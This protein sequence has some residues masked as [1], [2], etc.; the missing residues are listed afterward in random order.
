MSREQEVEI[1]QEGLSMLIKKGFAFLGI[2]TIYLYLLD[3]WLMITWIPN[4]IVIFLI[5][6]GSIVLFVKSRQFL[7][8]G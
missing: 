1:D 5:I 8:P 2:A 4:S 6:V 7:Q 3:N